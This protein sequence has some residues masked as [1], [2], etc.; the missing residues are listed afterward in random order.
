MDKGDV[1]KALSW[2]FL[3]LLIVVGII[4]ILLFNGY[5]GSG[6]DE[7]MNTCGDSSFYDSCSF[8]KPLFCSSTGI[9][10]EISSVCGCPEGYYF[11]EDS[12]VSNL[13]KGNKK[14]SFEYFFEGEKNN[15]RRRRPIFLYPFSQHFFCKL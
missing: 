1:K 7:R 14:S 8:S 4:L 6:N 13:Y 15:G 9:L 2:F 12:C 11:F 10:M 3:F 5:V